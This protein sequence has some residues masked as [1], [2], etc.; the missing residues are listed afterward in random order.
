MFVSLFPL[1]DCFIIMCREEHPEN[2]LKSMKT[3]MAVI[4]EESEDIR[5]DLLAIILSALGRNKKVSIP[6]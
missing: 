2:V 6:L 3:I 1:T 4:L 5:E